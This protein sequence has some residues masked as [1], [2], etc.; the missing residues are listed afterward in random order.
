[1]EDGIKRKS[2]VC[3]SMNYESSLLFNVSHLFY[4]ILLTF[5]SPPEDSFKEIQ[6]SNLA[7]FY[8]DWRIL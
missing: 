1:V 7:W 6:N 3:L 2:E 8:E 4:T 5:G